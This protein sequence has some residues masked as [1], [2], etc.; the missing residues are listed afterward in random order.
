MADAWLVIGFEPSIG[1]DLLRYLEALSTGEERGNR[2]FL[3]G[4]NLRDAEDA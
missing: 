1:E 4:G 2:R 3:D